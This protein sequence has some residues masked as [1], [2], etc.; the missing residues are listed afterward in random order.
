MMWFIGLKNDSFS[1]LFS[2]QFGRNILFIVAVFFFSKQFLSKKMGLKKKNKIFVIFFSVQFKHFRKKNSEVAKTILDKYLNIAWK[3]NL[4]RFMC[5]YILN[6][7]VYWI[8]V[9]ERHSHCYCANSVLLTCVWIVGIAVVGCWLA[10][11]IVSDSKTASGANAMR[12]LWRWCWNG[13][14]WDRWRTISVRHV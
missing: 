9:Y 13:W 7:I 5:E 14:Y 6:M 2:T 8:N 3:V 11:V 10:G 1:L 4:W 12:R